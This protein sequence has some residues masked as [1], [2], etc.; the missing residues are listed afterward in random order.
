LA[1]AR[2]LEFIEPSDRLSGHKGVICDLAWSP[3]GA[4][5]ASASRDRTIRLWNTDPWGFRDSL[6]GHS[7][8][9]TCLDWSPDSAFVA[10]GS[11]DQS[12]RIWALREGSCDSY[13]HG[14]QVDCVA[15]SPTGSLVA[16]GAR[17]GAVYLWDPVERRIRGRHVSH[18][19][20]V[21]ALA[22]SGD[23]TSLATASKDGTI[24]VWRPEDWTLG[25][26]IPIGHRVH[27]ICWLPGTDRLAVGSDETDVRIIA[28][29]GRA[30]PIVR[31]EWPSKAERS[32]PVM[33]AR[34]SRDGRILLTRSA[35]GSCV[36]WRCGTWK[37]LA[38]LKTS[39]SHSPIG[40]ISCHPRS[41]LAAGVADRCQGINVFRLTDIL[42]K[43]RTMPRD[44]RRTVLFL[45]ANPKHTDALRLGEEVKKVE[46]GLERAKLRDR[47]RLVQK[48]A[49]TDDDLRRA[50]LDHEPQIV[51]FSG[52]GAGASGLVFEDDS[53]EAH[54]ISGDALA[55]LFE[56]FAEH[57]QCVVL[58]ACYS[59]SQARAIAQY[60]D[61]VIGMRQAVGDEAAIKFSIGFYDALGAGRPYDTAFNFGRSAIALKGLPDHLTPVLLR[62]T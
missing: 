32:E 18:Q 27:N 1:H 50:L 42:K 61:Y 49:V 8:W 11:R 2:R 17:D 15:W 56:L 30:N 20:G 16:S 5:L 33:D 36:I 59:E 46:Q 37:P 22:W 57:V 9:V 29:G 58:N 21:T 23:G 14:D 31:L 10:S 35:D 13:W 12:V 25:R 6:L 54:E 39:G 62:R 40:G 38:R 4:T 44:D 51:H 3:D 47:F 45:A 41:L 34:L 53:G 48:S 55:E 28:V 26:S 24:S 19:R 60:I 7:S 52:H 43:D